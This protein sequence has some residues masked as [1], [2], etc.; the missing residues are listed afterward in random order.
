LFGGDKRFNIFGCFVVEFMQES[1]EAAE[2]ELGVDLAI[3]TEKLSFQAILDR[4][5]AN[6]ASKM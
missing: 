6:A 3:C 2:S 1:F 5:R 4:N